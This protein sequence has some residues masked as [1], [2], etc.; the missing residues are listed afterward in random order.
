MKKTI[1]ILLFWSI[2]I[3]GFAQSV[4]I[5]PK[6]N[7]N[8]LVNIQSTTK[9]EVMARM[10][11][12]QRNVMSGLIQ[13]TQVY[14]TDCTPAGAYFFDGGSWVA[15]FQTTT[16]SPI[17]Y[18]VGQMAQG[19]MVIWIDPASGGQ[20]GLA[21]AMT[22]FANHVT[23]TFWDYYFSSLPNLYV[24]A[25]AKGYYGGELNTQLILIA[26]KGN[27]EAALRSRQVND[28][29]YGDWYLPSQGELDLIYSLRNTIGS[30]SFIGLSTYPIYSSSTETGQN[31]AYARNFLTG[32]QIINQPKNTGLLA[33]AIRR[34]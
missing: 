14:C 27:G 18:T 9:A 28:G 34:F 6:A 32:A 16:V 22:D 15:M 3:H 25:T 17:T 11:V 10:T 7:N 26:L 1:S 24:G 33:R 8:P 12:A 30:S 4:T 20:H 5:D 2:R 31:T 13:G 19:G 29:G 21:V 23:G